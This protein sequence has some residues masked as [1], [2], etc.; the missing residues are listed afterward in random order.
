VKKL[1]KDKDLNKYLNE[2]VDA[3]WEASTDGNNHV[4]LI[5]PEGLQI[6]AAV[7]PSDR[8]AHKAVKR[9]VRNREAWGARHHSGA[10]K[11]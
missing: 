7:T 9:L 3:G 8:N 2:L 10:V 4:K 5:S 1:S 11:T 6:R